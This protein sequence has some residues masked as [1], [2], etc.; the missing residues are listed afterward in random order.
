[1]FLAQ[2]DSLMAAASSILGTT[3]VEDVRELGLYWKAYGPAAETP[4]AFTLQSEE[5]GDGFVDPGRCTLVLQ[6]GWDGQ[7]EVLERRR[8]FQLKGPSRWALLHAEGLVFRR[9]RPTE[10]AG[11]ALRGVDG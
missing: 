9:E 8:T 6:M 1:M 7:Q 11:G 3:D 2:A 5:K 10:S 4:L